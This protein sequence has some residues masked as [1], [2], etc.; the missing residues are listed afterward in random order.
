[1]A[2]AVAPTISLVLSFDHELSLGGVSDYEK[3]LFAP[4]DKLIE[5]AEDLNVPLSLFTDILCLAK[6]RE[7]K[8]LSFCDRFERQIHHTLKAGHDVQLHI[9]PHW[10][11]TEYRGGRFVPSSRYSL[12]YF[13]EDAPP[14]DIH[15]IVSAAATLLTEVCRRQVPGYRCVAFRAGGYSLAPHTDQILSALYENGVRIDSS[16]AKGFVF[17]SELYSAD[18]R[19]MPKAPNWF[20]PLQGPLTS[21]AEDGLFEIPIA[22]APRTPWNNLPFLVKRVLYRKRAYSS[23]GVGLDAGHVSPFQKLRRMFPRTAWMLSFDN[24]T[25]DVK[26]LVSI[27]RRHAKA[28]RGYDHIICSAIAHPKSMGAYS[29]QLMADFVRRIQ[30]MKSDIRV[31]FTTYRDIAESLESGRIEL[32]I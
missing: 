28:S 9:H 17:R 22:S 23:G 5:L 4:T 27:L 14:H 18:F 21:E 3:N 2:S 25:L 7:W 16:I 12:G 26:S 10:I 13:A 24:Y 19:D 1:M 11:D 29:L 20:I 30:D 15:G 8:E 32:V 31:E 6:F